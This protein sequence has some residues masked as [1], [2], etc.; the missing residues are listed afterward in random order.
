MQ[1]FCQY[2]GH[3]YNWIPVFWLRVNGSLNPKAK[4]SKAD[5]S[6]WNCKLSL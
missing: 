6:Y 5:T 1:L 4:V 2:C 3:Y